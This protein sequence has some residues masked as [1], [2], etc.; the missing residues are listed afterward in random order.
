M[1]PIKLTITC[2][3][4]FAGNLIAKANAGHWRGREQAFSGVA[5][6]TT[7]LDM[8]L[9]NNVG[10]VIAPILTGVTVPLLWYEAYLGRA[11]IGSHRPSIKGCWNRCSRAS[12]A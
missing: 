3:P 5:R 12:F 1:A 4:V 2:V 10:L 9:R 11:G 8:N 6:P 7:I